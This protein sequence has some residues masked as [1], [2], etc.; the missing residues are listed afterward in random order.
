[1]SAV[2]MT[3]P[4]VITFARLVAAPITVWCI[5]TDAWLAAFVLFVAAGVSDALD[6]YLA[7]RFGRETT[8]GSYLDPIADKVLMAGVYVSLGARGHLPLLVV[9]LVVFRDVIIIGGVV[10]L[11]IFSEIEKAEPLIVSKLNTVAQVGLAAATLYG[12]GVGRLPATVLP[13]LA[14]TVAATTCI[15][16]AHYAIEF[17]RRARGHL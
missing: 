12:L 3:L 17:A 1:M 5:L 15:S 7:R 13:A 10:M 4:N 14:I 6:G 2:W 9:I 16:G 8:L 11:H